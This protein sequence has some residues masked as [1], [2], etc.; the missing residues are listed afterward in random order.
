MSRDPFRRR[1][2]S[3]RGFIRLTLAH[4]QVAAGRAFEKRPDPAVVRRLVFVCHGNICRSAFAHVAAERAGY[5]V[6]SFGLSTGSGSPAHPPAVAAAH[7][8]GVDL[9][10]HRTTRVQDFVAEEGDLLLAMEVRQ[11]GRLAA[12]P[13][14]AHLPRLL[15]G[16]FARPRRPHLHDPYRLDPAYMDASL[17]VIDDAVRRLCAAYPGARSS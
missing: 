5:R 11:L 8:L 12:D 15:L 4:L 1:Y 2:G 7:T 10:A 16:S 3:H 14:L 17:R 9:D 13:R 6:A